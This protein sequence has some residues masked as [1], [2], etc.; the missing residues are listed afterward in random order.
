[1]AEVL[2]QRSA[3]AT[4]VAVEEGTQSPAIVASLPPEQLA[5]EQPCIKVKTSEVWEVPSFH[6]SLRDGPYKGLC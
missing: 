2:I 1:M 3:W 5:S 4:P 6:P